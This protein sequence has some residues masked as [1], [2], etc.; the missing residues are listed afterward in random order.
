[1]LCFGLSHACKQGGDAPL[2]AKENVPQNSSPA[3]AA[4]GR[5]TRR[6]QAKHSAEHAPS[7]QQ[8]ADEADESAAIHAAPAQLPLL[9]S[10]VKAAAA[11]KVG[12]QCSHSHISSSVS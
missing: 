12:H 7:G 10:V 11:A 4:E 2:G 5:T 9:G 1:M 8:P 3:A 6:K